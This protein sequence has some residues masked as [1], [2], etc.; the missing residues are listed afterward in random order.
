MQRRF[1]SC[2]LSILRLFCA[3]KLG[4]L[5]IPRF[6]IHNSYDGISQQLI[7]VVRVYDSAGKVIEM[8]HSVNDQK[9]DG[10]CQV[11]RQRRN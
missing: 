4:L 9:L 5:K 11:D 3:E 10:Q 6:S 1:L 8:H 7:A 2:A